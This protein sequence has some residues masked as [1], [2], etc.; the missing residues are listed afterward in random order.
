MKIIYTF[1]LNLIDIFFS[2]YK[3]NLQTHAYVCVCGG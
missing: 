1:K 3:I 2:L